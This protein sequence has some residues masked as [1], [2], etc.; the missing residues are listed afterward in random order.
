[1]ICRYFKTVF[2]TR[3]AHYH[4][5]HMTRLRRNVSTSTPTRISLLDVSNY[6]CSLQIEP[7]QAGV[8][9]N[10]YTRFGERPTAF[11]YDQTTRIPNS[12]LCNA[13]VKGKLID[14]S[15]DPYIV[16]VGGTVIRSPGYVFIG[17]QYNI[18]AQKPKSRRKRS[19]F[20]SRRQKRSCI[21]PKDA[22][23]PENVTIIPRYD[24]ENDV[25]YTMSIQETKCLY[26]NKGAQKW[27]SN[28]CKVSS[29]LLSF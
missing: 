6:F 20:D 28:G 2:M 3:S 23:Q 19:C 10:V 17:V 22:P 21:E 11:I 4:D 9:L 8:S 27:V 25:N 29:Q 14:C 13:T 15:V 12:S 24:P 26:W 5:V 7:T 1:M 18:N 16:T